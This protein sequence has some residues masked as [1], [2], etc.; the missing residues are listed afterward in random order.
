MK[1]KIHFSRVGKNESLY[2]E[3]LV[4]KDDKK[5][6]THSN[7][8]AD[9][10]HIWKKEDWIQKGIID[11][12]TIVS[13][14]RKHHFFDEWFDVI[15]LIDPRGQLIGYYCDVITPLKCVDGEYYLRDLLLDLWVFPDRRT[16]VLA[17]DEFEEAA[18]TE[19]IS[20]EEKRMAE[21]TLRRMEQE[22]K[23]GKFPVLY[24]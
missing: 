21:D 7:L 22:T 17:W 13:Q 11:Q 5:I 19:Q 15:E 23:Q 10:Q 20:S 12:Q 18:R 14:V 4:Y 2:I 16:I 1:V 3:P 8:P 6:I 24:L 9:L